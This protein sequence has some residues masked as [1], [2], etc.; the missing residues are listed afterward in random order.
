MATQF[1]LQSNTVATTATL[2]QHKLTAFIY[3][4]RSNF[5]SYVILRMRTKT[6]RSANVFNRWLNVLCAFK[7]TDIARFL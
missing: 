6:K 1:S 2:Q 3:M 7:N 5:R 4:S